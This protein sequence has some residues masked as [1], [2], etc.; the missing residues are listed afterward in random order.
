ME[1]ASVWSAVRRVLVY[2]GA[3]TAYI[4][5]QS[6]Q[7]NSIAYGCPRRTGN[8]LIIGITVALLASENLGCCEMATLINK[9]RRIRHCDYPVWA[10]KGD[11]FLNTIS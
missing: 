10:N 9:S 3:S 11:G 7:K 2:I 4:I 6:D 8:R 1:F 5:S